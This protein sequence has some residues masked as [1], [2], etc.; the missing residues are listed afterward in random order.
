MFNKLDNSK[1]FSTKKNDIDNLLIASRACL[2]HAK[3]LLVSAKAVKAS[4]HPNI[5]YHLAAL[6]LEEIGRMELLQMKQ[7]AHKQGLEKTGWGMLRRAM[8]RNYFGVCF[9]LK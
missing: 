6:S 7:M 4:G 8:L 9:H 5:S 3:S 2:D 1:N